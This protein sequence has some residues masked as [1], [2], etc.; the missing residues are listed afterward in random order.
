V[1]DVLSGTVDQ[2]QAHVEEIS[3]PE[4]IQELRGRELDRRRPR[5]GVLS[6]LNDREAELAEMGGARQPYRVRRPVFLDG[7]WVTPLHPERLE[8]VSESTIAEA[9][10]SGAI[11]R[12]DG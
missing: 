3:D 8:G 6:A 11:E 2:V 1:D 10:K 12:L 4:G 7:R 5:K 9:L